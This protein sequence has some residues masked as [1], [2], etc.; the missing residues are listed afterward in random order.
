M[1][2]MKYIVRDVYFRKKQI[3]KIS[4]RLYNSDEDEPSAGIASKRVADEKKDAKSLSRMKGAMLCKHQLADW[5]WLGLEY[6][7]EEANLKVQ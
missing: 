4:M 2:S 3:V 1:K 6:L 7:F 5:R